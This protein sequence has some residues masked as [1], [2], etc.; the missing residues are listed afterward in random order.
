VSFAPSR[1]S[2]DLVTIL[3]RHRPEASL[4]E[5]HRQHALV[6]LMLL[7]AWNLGVASAT[8]CKCAIFGAE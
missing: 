4:L 5:Q 3:Q 2:D 6:G 7:E 1:K 8:F